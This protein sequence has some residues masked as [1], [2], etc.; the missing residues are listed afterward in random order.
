MFQQKIPK[1]NSQMFLF[2]RTLPLECFWNSYVRLLLKSVEYLFLE[3][4]FVSFDKSILLYRRCLMSKF[5]GIL[6]LVGRKIFSNFSN[7]TFSK[8]FPPYVK[9][10]FS[11]VTWYFMIGGIFFR[12]RLIRKTFHWVSDHQKL[13]LLGYNLKN[14]LTKHFPEI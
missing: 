3:A 10:S 2:Y 6:V 1:A 9:V 8:L 12:S 5:S 11:L 14:I 13:P 4:F 7:E